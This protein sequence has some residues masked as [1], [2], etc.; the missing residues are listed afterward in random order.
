MHLLVLLI[1][2]AL[3]AAS[4]DAAHASSPTVQATTAT[5]EVVIHYRAWNGRSRAAY[6]LLPAWYRPWS[7][8]SIPLVISPHG[9]GVGGRAN[10]RLWGSLPGI[11]GFALVSPDGQGR[12]LARYAWG[13]AG[14]IRDLARMPVILERALPWLRIQQSR[15]YA[16]GGSMGGQE[17]LLL[18]ARHPRLLA[19]VAAFDS[20]ADVALQYRNFSRLRCNAA[21]G[22]R[23]G[24]PL[25]ASLRQ[26]EREEIG[27]SPT[28]QPRA[29]ARRSPLTYS[30]TIARSCVPLE[31]WWSR[32]DRVV[33]D[34]DR[35]SA[36][37]FRRL[38][39]VNP[40]APVQGLVGSWIH[41]AEMV[42]HRLL[43]LALAQFGLVPPSLKLRPGGLHVS[44]TAPPTRARCLAQRVEQG[45]REAAVATDRSP[46]GAT[47]TG[48]ASARPFARG[49]AP[50]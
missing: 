4:H 1:V 49:Q 22:R 6:V 44:P 2:A 28:D 12:K 14:D 34:Q 26:R 30:R 27:G 23:L 13:W 3:V 37:L 40:A 33:V 50:R 48:T 41:S 20:V 21:C 17:V 16:V 46:H 24:E 19:G 7:R 9:R 15:I 11:G 45:Q 18:L 47:A 35:Q 39:A 36:R 8:R 29:Y 5:R 31:L 42:S 10:A 32:F 25:G 43:P 38:H